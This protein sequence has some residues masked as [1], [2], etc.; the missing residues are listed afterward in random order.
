M[1]KVTLLASALGVGIGFGL[2]NVVNNFVSGPD[3]HRRAPGRR[4]RRDRVGSLAGEV[5]R[6]GIRSSTVRTGQGAEVIVPNGDLVSKEV[7]N[8]TAP[9]ASAATTSMSASPR[10]P[11][12]NR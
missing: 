12:R 8:W 1:A 9:T 11:S 7:V 4:G 3:P 5:K 2:Q 6:I 10:V